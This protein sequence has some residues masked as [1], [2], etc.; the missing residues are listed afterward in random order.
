MRVLFTAVL[1]R[2][3]TPEDFG[4]IATAT[5]VTGFAE[6]FVQFGFGQGLVQKKEISKD[7]VGTAYTSSLVLGLGFGLLLV[8]TAPLIATFF[9]QP[10]LTGILRLLAILFPLKSLN[11]VQFSILQRD[12]KFKSLAG[13]DVLSYAIGYGV[14]GI[15]LA[16]FD[17]GV[18]A[19]VYALL[20]QAL[21]YSLLLGISQRDFKLR[22]SF[23]KESYS[24]LFNFGKNMT[25]VK[26]FNYLALKGDYFMVS[27]FLGPANLGFYSRAYGLMNAPNSI[28]GATLNTV[29]FSS[30]S[31]DQNDRE[32]QYIVLKKSFSLVIF[33][34]FLFLPF[35]ILY[36]R[37]IVLILLGDQWLKVIAP[38]Q[39]LLGGF[40]F[41]L[42]YKISSSF[43]RR[44]KMLIFQMRSQFLY[45]FLVCAGSFLGSM[46][47][48]ESVAWFVN[49]ALLIN[50][51][52][53]TN[54]VV[55]ESY[56]TWMDIINESLKALLFSIPLLLLS[57]GLKHL[58]INLEISFVWLLGIGSLFYLALTLLF[59]QIGLIPG[60][61]VKMIRP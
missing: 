18:M 11:Q 9:E 30:F 12:M 37:E 40:A 20:V 15:T 33:L 6:L 7:D 55:N 34:V 53:L 2:L 57:F 35:L 43:L 59:I 58:L 1:A 22:F 61:I 13:R 54:K 48:I 31:K 49:L 50:F 14:V 42:L 10:E 47:S 16:Y 36:S 3:L 26:I 8:F 4:L 23:N 27:K 46:Y 51:V 24:H 29:L 60:R 56:L 21:V 25:L 19:L 5:I 44:G 17:Y 39:I 41:R 45:M 38:F 28:I 32:R 52:V